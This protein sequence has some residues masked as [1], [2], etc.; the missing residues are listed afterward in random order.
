[1]NATANLRADTICRTVELG[2]TITDAAV[3]D[4]L[5]HLF[6]TPVTLDPVCAE[7]RTAGCLRDHVQ[8]KVTDLPI[9]GHPTR[10]HV[11]VPRL[12]CDNDGCGTRIFQQRMPALAEPRAKTTRR[13]SRW[14]LQRLA[15]D[16]TSVSAVAKALGLGGVPMWIVKSQTGLSRTSYGGVVAMID[17]RAASCGPVVINPAAY[18][19]VAMV[20]AG[21]SRKNSRRVNRA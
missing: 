16:R 9:V 21:I 19:A 11:R 17:R 13:C 8:R 20:L 18:A 6:C 14:I 7:C 2:V 10:L 4:D 5:T 12:T 3:A 1:M 15:I